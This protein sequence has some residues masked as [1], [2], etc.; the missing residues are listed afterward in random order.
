[1]GLRS[2]HSAS[3]LKRIR[4]T[5]AGLPSWWLVVGRLGA[6]WLAVVLQGTTG[7]GTEDAA[8]GCAFETATALIPDDPA[9]GCA[10]QCP[11]DGALSG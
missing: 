6:A 5:V 11:G 4:V 8:E 2:C 10:K 7:Q 9:C 1:M 3:R